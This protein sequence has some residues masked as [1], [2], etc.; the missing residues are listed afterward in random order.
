S[1]HDE[2]VVADDWMILL[3]IFR[4]TS[5]DRGLAS[6]KQASIIKSKH[7]LHRI[8]A[9]Y[10]LSMLNMIMIVVPSGLHRIRAKYF[11]SMLNM[12][13]LPCASHDNREHI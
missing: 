2:V 10:F 3:L 1:R 12:I 6:T 4:I 13:M 7:G 11:L 9:K 8:R 5:A